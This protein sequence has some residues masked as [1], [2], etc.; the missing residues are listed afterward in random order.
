VNEPRKK[1]DKKLG[2]TVLKWVKRGLGILFVL[3]VVAMLV[4]AWM[5]KPVP[6]DGIAAE[7]GPLLVTVDESGRTRVKDRYVVSAPL[8]GNVAR[9]DLDPGDTI[10]EGAEIARVLSLEPPLMDARSRAQA[11]ARVAAARAAVRQAR[12]TQGRIEA[13]ASFAAREAERQ[14]GLARR[15]SVAE[16][17]AERAELE[18][19]TAREELS[20]AAFAVRVADYELRVAEAALRRQ[21][22][23]GGRPSAAPVDGD[24]QV[25]VNAPVAGKVLRVIQESEG[26]VQA[27]TPLVELGDAS[28]L[29]IVVDV[30]TSDAVH[31]EPGA[32]VVIERWGGEQP[33]HGHVRIVEPSAFTRMSALGV[34]EQRVNVIIDLDE[35]YEVWQS[36]GDG[37]RVEAK[38]IIW[39][40]ENVLRVP[41]SA[42]FRQG[43]GWALYAIR[44]GAASL[45]A[46]EVGHKNGLEVE[47]L[48]GIDEGT[49][50]ILHPS[51]QISDG[52]EVE[53]R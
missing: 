27:G 6:V 4:T 17:A 50:I 44:D 12:A 23:G 40:A 30:L 18:S 8:S 37:Y 19:R 52:V 7:S 47:I 10:E 11:E 29:E 41:A 32:R 24:E 38:I 35:D 22:G 45:T 31:I 5:P 46:V 21:G 33:L 51:D 1:N 26:V 49:E 9:I 14:R 34:E 39:E 36:L 48:S 2:K 42:V 25:L 3:G 13:S 53:R 16:L 20:S 28:A 15:G 43:E